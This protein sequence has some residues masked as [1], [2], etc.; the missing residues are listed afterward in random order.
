MA[1]ARDLTEFIMSSVECV[2]TICRIYFYSCILH[3]RNSSLD[4]RSIFVYIDVSDRGSDQSARRRR[5]SQY[6]SSRS[7]ILYVDSDC[8][9]HCFHSAIKDSLRMVDDL[10]DSC[11]SESTLK[12][13]HKYWSSLAK[14][15]NIWRERA[16]TIMD[17]WDLHHSQRS[18][19][20]GKEKSDL[21]EQ[22]RRYPLNVVAGRWGC[23]ERAEE[24]L[25]ERGKDNVV[26][27][28]LAALSS[29]MKSS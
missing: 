9:L 11:F 12:G 5:T 16:K 13:F 2:C 22:G 15:T 17:C 7:S 21:L 6:L 10:I 27:V 26:P 24:F 25:L 29:S 3:V 18:D 19:V 28:L 14:V 8:Y 1:L 20:A 23:V 4:H